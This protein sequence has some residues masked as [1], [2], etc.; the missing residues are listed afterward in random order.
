MC[1]CIAQTRMVE[2]LQFETDYK[3][4][5]LNLRTA[6]S[7]FNGRATAFASFYSRMRPFRTV[8][9]PACCNEQPMGRALLGPHGAL[10]WS[11]ISIDIARVRSGSLN[12]V[13]RV[14]ASCETQRDVCARNGVLDRISKKTD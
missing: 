3:S 13:H 6:Y 10:A 12:P 8:K 1:E 5:I 14:D 7:R 4:G 2:Q 11:R 9:R